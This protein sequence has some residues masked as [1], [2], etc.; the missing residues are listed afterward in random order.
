MS[1]V[2]TRF[3]AALLFSTFKGTPILSGAYD[4]IHDHVELLSLETAFEWLQVHYPE[5][6]TDV[7]KMISEDQEEPLPLNWGVLIQDWDNTY[8]IVWIYI[9][10]VL[11][12]RDGETFRLRHPQFGSW[13]LEMNE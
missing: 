13:L 3:K 1:T 6:H 8:W 4:H 5:I 10:W 2:Y 11:W 7:T 9:V 12:A